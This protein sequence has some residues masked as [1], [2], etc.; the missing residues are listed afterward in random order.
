MDSKELIRLVVLVS[1]VVLPGCVKYYQ[2]IPTEFPQ[3][4]VT[5]SH[6]Q[7]TEKYV[8][9][10]TVL[11]Q[12]TTKAVFD[13]VWMSDQMRTFYADAHCTKRGIVN[14]AKE[15]FLK[16][17][18]EENRHWVAFYVLAD[19]RD[20]NC[21]SLSEPNA[22]WTVS[23]RVD[24]KHIFS[25]ERVKEVELDQEIQHCFGSRFIPAKTAYLVKF[26]I[27]SDVA[28]LIARDAFKTIELVLSSMAKK[29]TLC[30]QRDILKTSH[31]VVTSNEDFYW[32]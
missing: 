26:P 22:A 10:A 14:D 13:A 25:P 8:K 2:T 1:C 24:G 21:P 4:E 29:T 28:E 11:D 3:G 30:W 16:R 23:L 32:G 20:K 17:Q 19:V 15:E 27:P 6:A 12:F 18:L 31:K 5:E 9:S 7:I